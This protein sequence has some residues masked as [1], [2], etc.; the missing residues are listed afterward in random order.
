MFYFVWG[1]KYLC[2]YSQ[3][4]QCLKLQW[5]SSIYFPIRL[6]ISLI[7][8]TFFIVRLTDLVL[9]GNEEHFNVVGSIANILLPYQV[10]CLLKCLLCM[11]RWRKIVTS[12]LEF[13]ELVVS[14]FE[15]FQERI[16]QIVR[17]NFLQFVNERLENMAL[18]FSECA[19]VRFS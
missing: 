16:Q 7:H 18:Q 15:V 9:V 12:L 6:I 19:S 2:V 3:I 10:E 11:T 5:N 4:L 14:Q 1:A 8:V 17:I 13:L